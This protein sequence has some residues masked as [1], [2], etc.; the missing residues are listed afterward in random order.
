MSKA[1][2]SA[3]IWAREGR[4][5]ASTCSALQKLPTDA[6]PS[7]RCNMTDP[8]GFAID[9]PV[10]KLGETLKLPPWLEA[11]RK[12]IEQVLPPIRLHRTLKKAQA[13]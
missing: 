10:E 5:L 12:R 9:E 3:L 13:S 11:S 8:P 4:E 2:G 6:L 1:T 7:A